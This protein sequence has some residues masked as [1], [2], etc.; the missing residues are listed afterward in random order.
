MESHVSEHQRPGIEQIVC[1]WGIVLA[2]AILFGGLELL[3]PN[4]LVRSSG[5]EVATIQ[6]T[7]DRQAGQAELGPIE[8]AFER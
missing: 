4:T 8:F 6:R 3:W 2:I 7:V 5:F 1:A